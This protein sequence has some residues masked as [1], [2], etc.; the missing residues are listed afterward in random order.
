MHIYLAPYG[1]WRRRACE[2]NLADGGGGTGR[3]SWVGSGR[4]ELVG[5]GGGAGPAGRG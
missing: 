2:K 1:W 5:D 4:V 3:A